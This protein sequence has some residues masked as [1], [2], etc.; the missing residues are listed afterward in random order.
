MFEEERAVVE[1]LNEFNSVDRVTISYNPSSGSEAYIIKVFSE[2][3]YGRK[4]T[5]NEG[6]GKSLKDA[7]ESILKGAEI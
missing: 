4:V 6:K 7:K 3:C 1:L 2:S 5:I